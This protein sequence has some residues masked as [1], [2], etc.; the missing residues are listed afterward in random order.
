V[1]VIVDES[2]SFTGVDYGAALAQAAKFGGNLILTTQGAGFIGR[3]VASDETD[4]PQAFSKILSNVD[5]L[6]VYRVSGEDAVGLVESEFVGEL[7]PPDLIYL[8]DHQAFV[9]FKKDGQLV[10]PFR[11]RMDPPPPRDEL[12]AA[13]VLAGRIRYTCDLAEALARAEQAG[14]RLETYFGSA[15]A[16]ETAAYDGEIAAANL[17]AAPERA[18]LNGR[19]R[20]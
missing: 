2:Q 13:A 9:R 3:S 20:R 7:S 4:D 16:A 14:R 12:I 17:P 19:W 10:G 1:T 15:L 6:I 18:S 11:V 5:T 8:P